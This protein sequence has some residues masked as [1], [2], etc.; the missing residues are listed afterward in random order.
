MDNNQWLVAIANL[1]DIAM[2]DGMLVG[3]EKELLEVYLE[4]FDV[5]ETDVKKT[6]EVISI[7]KAI[8][9]LTPVKVFSTMNFIG[10]RHGKDLYSS[11]LLQAFP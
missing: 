8:I 7:K 6:V 2:A 10:V 11:R 9:P 5:N 1:V 3:K 4:A